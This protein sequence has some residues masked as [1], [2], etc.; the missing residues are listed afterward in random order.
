MIA[1]YD[2]LPPPNRVFVMPRSRYAENFSCPR[3]VGLPERDAD[4]CAT[5]DRSETR[6]EMKFFPAIAPPWGASCKAARFVPIEQ[7]LTS[8]CSRP[9]EMP[10]ISGAAHAPRDKTPKDCANTGYRC[11]EMPM[12]EPFR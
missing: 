5:L 11:H 10:E 4:E 8:A 3:P 2:L 12:E 1:V 7:R 6:D 9:R